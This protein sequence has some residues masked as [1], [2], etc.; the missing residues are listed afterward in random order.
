MFTVMK[1]REDLSPGDYRDPVWY[2]HPK[3][4]VAYEVDVAAAG[5][6]Q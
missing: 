1:V 2:K 5:A 3:G 6:P 4:S